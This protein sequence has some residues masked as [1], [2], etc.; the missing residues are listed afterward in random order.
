MR[1]NGS[2]SAKPGTDRPR[3]SGTYDP[4]DLSHWDDRMPVPRSLGLTCG[5]CD[6]DLTGL[7]QRSCPDC[8]AAFHLPI[9]QKLDLRCCECGYEL[10]WL[11]TRICPECGTGF[12]VSGLIFAERMRKRRGRLADRVPWHDLLRW[13]L[14]SVL[15]CVGLGLMFGTIPGV[16]YACVLVAALVGGKAYASGTEPSRIALWAG[17]FFM[18]IGGML[19]LLL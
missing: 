3:A 17:V 8:G 13:V 4:L 15:G 11:M 5:G 12:D 16:P 6:R 9:P 7:D 14:A 18:I 2:S 19:A 10:A 1:R